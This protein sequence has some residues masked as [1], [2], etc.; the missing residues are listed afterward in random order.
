[1]KMLHT[2]VR[3]IAVEHF[4]N[5]LTVIRKHFRVPKLHD[6]HGLYSFPS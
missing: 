2:N 6:V 4:H 3:S 5:L 1:L